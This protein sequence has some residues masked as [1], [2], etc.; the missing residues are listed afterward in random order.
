MNAPHN[1]IPEQLVWPANLNEVPKEVFYREDIYQLEMER[2][3]MGAF[4]HPVAHV[5]EIPGKGDFK[6]FY[7]GETPILIIHGE[8]GQ[9]RVF[10]NTCT[11]RGTLLETGTRGNKTAYECPYHRWLFDSTGAL[12]GCPAQEDYSPG[13]D[14]ADYGLLELRS[15][16]FCGV[17]FATASDATVPL[18]QF[19][20]DTA[21]VV[22]KS[23]GGGGPLRLL[24]Y[25]KVRYQ[26]NWKA[27]IDNDGFHAP[28]LHKAF[29]LLNWQGGKGR[30]FA[31]PD[32]GHVAF[33]SELKVPDVGDFLHDPSLVAFEGADPTEGSALVSMTPI[34]AFIRHMDLLN[35]RFAFPAG[36]DRTEVHYAYFARQDDDQEMARHRL[37]QSSNLIGPS[38]M[39]SLED[40]AMFHRVHQG[41]HTPGNAYFQKGVKD[42][43]G[44]AYEFKQNDEWGNVPR[45]EMYR[46]LLGFARAG[47]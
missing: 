46:K 8:D 11:H 10:F 17:V 22:E 16:I 27:Y 37:R 47:E 39:V 20:G 24:G 25:Q 32:F 45:W 19:I 9:V 38:G 33:V 40:A 23:L 2:I 5:A 14:R 1:A 21:P 30:Q 41:A 7:L 36:I 15:E 29:K 18:A 3:F 26:S 43:R 31:T 6:T 12:R 42:P 4:W 34:S 44:L 35:I 28:L 13:F